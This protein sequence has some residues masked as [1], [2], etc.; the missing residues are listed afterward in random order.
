MEVGSP[1]WIEGWEMFW[2]LDLEG[3]EFVVKWGQWPN[4]DAHVAAWGL[5]VSQPWSEW[6]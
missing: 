4:H 1:E 3:K 5:E 2:A 6:Y